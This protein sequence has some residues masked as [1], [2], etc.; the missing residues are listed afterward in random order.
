MERASEMEPGNER[1][2]VRS[3][4]G[5]QSKLVDKIYGIIVSSSAWKREHMRLGCMC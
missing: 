2:A 1:G 5:R 4:M 3:L